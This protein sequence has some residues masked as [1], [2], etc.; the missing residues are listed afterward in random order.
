[1]QLLR[2][3]QRM[4]R[5]SGNRFVD[6]NMRQT[7]ISSSPAAP[8]EARIIDVWRRSVQCGEEPILYIA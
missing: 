1:M 8:F 6:K 3:R 7:M 4:F 2:L 5:R